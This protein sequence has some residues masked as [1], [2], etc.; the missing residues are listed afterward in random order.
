MFVCFYVSIF[1]IDSLTLPID[2]QF[3]LLDDR[4][5]RSPEETDSDDKNELL[6]EKQIAWLIKELK[7]S[8]ANFKIIAMGGQVLNP[9]KVEETYANY[10]EEWKEFL[11][12]LDKEKIPG[13]VFLSGDRHFSEVMKMETA[14]NYPIYEFTVSPLNSG[15]YIDVNE[16]NPLRIPGS[17][18]T[19]YNFATLDFYGAGKERAMRVQY[20]NKD[21]VLLFEKIIKAEELH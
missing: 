6:G 18:I 3:F 9:L 13:I 4:T 2:V 7:A 14:K 21:G 16:K 20:R 5:F 8:K 17:L 15:P 19:Q 12:Q 11:K 1:S 10:K